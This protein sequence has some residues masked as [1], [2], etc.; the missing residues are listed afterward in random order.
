MRHAERHQH[1]G[2]GHDGLPLRGAR[3]QPRQEEA[4]P[5]AQQAAAHRNQDGLRQELADDIVAAGARGAAHAERRIGTKRIST[6]WFSAA[7]IL[8][9]IA[10]E[11]PS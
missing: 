6:L 8:R 1:R 3:D 11:W 5:D 4:E 9:S 7:A 2:G 10:T